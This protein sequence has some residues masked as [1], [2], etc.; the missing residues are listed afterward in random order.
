MQ[1]VSGVDRSPHEPTE[2]RLEPD[3]HGGLA[4]SMAGW[5]VVNLDAC[6]WQ[7]N[8]RFGLASRFETKDAAFPE[9]GMHVHVLEPGQ[10]ACMYH[11][12]N[13]QED[14]LVLFGECRLLIEE[15]ERSLR[16]WDFV[17]CPPGATHVFVGAG[18]GPCAILMIG[19]RKG[20]S[21]RVTYPVSELASRHGAGVAR[22]TDDPKEAYEGRPPSVAIPSPWAEL[23]ARR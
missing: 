20:A 13:C 15:Q 6:A 14:F 5:F 17:H 19:D 12:E 8:E 18:D 10:A 4:P 7:A 11:R 23:L 22:E 2:A 16:A 21:E 9:V 3:G 1:P